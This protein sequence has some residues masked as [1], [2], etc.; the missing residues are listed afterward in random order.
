[1]TD[2][3]RT[4]VTNPTHLGRRSCNHSRLLAYIAMEIEIARLT[5]TEPMVRGLANI[6]AAL[7]PSDCIPHAVGGEQKKLRLTRI[8]TPIEKLAGRLG[9]APCK[10]LS[11][12]T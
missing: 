9:A 3:K 12:A 1:M 11:A 8:G 2:A 10:R 5:A 6:E 7:R 4:D